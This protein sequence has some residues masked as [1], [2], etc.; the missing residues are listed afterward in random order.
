MQ[1]N[2][3]QISLNDLLLLATSGKKSGVLKLVRGKE[4][5]EV[6][7][8]DGTIVHATCPIGEGEKALLYPVTW[9][10]GAFTL[11]PERSAVTTTIQ[12]SSVEL[13]S[14]IKSMTLEWETILE[15]IPSGQ[16][17]FRLAD[18]R[19]DQ[20]GP[21]TVPNVGWRVLS[22]LDGVRTIQEVAEVLRIPY[23]YVA[24]VMF[25]L[26]KA[27][28]V[29]AVAP[30]EKPA[31]DVV[32]PALLARATA[33]LTE[34]LGPMAPLVVRDQIKTLGASPTSL[35]ETKL[36]DLILLI[37][38]EIGDPKLKKKFEQSMYQEIANFKRL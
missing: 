22:K 27:G 1:G 16:S 15:L 37:G 25:N 29:E 3:Q 7:L 36:D 13:L 10:D 26:H 18:L 34:V 17:V 23:A 4:T 6:Y 12:K 38:L 30:I 20:T 5:V 21:I 31:V 19:D 24:K 28:L 14:E 32:P 11:E 2:L 35:P 8:T 33:L 9:S